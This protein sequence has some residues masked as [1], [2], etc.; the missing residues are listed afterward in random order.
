MIRPTVSHAT[1]INS[2]TA[3][4]E[5]RVA[6]HETVSSNPFVN[7]EPC[8]AHGTAAT[9]TPC[10]AHRTRGAAPTITAW[11]VPKSNARQ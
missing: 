8:R 3:D 4:F 9:T 5:H 10:S 6:S 2:L 7:P 1:R 11:T